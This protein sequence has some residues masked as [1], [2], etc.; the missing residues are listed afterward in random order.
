MLLQTAGSDWRNVGIGGILTIL[1]LREVFGFLKPMLRKTPEDR[2]VAGERSVEF[3]Q[4]EF[5]RAV[6]AGIKVL[7]EKLTG[8]MQALDEKI[9]RIGR[10]VEE[11]RDDA[12]GRWGPRRG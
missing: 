3:W 1:V 8:S 7:D 11:I 10:H 2:R 9:D 4:I 12:M 5:R 6:D